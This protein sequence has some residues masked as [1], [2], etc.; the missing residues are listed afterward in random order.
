MQEADDKKK[1]LGKTT[2]IG[3]LLVTSPFILFCIETLTRTIFHYSNEWPYPGGTLLG[4]LG[5]YTPFVAMYFIR[6]SDNVALKVYSWLILSVYLFWIIMIM[7]EG[8]SA[9]E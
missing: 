1:P 4:V 2:V 5:L 8:R 9:W 7:I 6:R 3:G